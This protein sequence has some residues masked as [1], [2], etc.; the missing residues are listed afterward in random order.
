MGEE[1][2]EPPAQLA[3][4]TGVWG[5]ATVL[6]CGALLASACAGA[7]TAPVGGAAAPAVR[8]AEHPKLGKILVGGNGM[9]LYTFSADSPG[10]ST[11]YDVCA[12]RWPP[13]IVSGT[14]AV[15]PGLAHPPEIGTVRRRDGSTQ[16]AYDGR[17][18]YLYIEDFA[19]GD[20]VGQAVNLDGGFWFV[21]QDP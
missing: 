15:G 6:L 4:S 3:R 20:A 13:L 7:A 17:P 1:A 18:L 14:P 12:Q 8:V 21:V 11:C 19:P 5:A 2:C 16:I 10:R 9:T